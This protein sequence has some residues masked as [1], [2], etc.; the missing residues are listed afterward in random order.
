MV[1]ILN[2][3]Y[4][5]T[6]PA[7]V[8]TKTE[9]VTTIDIGGDDD[10]GVVLP[11]PDG[12]RDYN[13]RKSNTTSFNGFGFY[14]M[15]DTPYR[16]WQEVRLKIQAGE[17]RKHVRQ[18]PDRNLTFTVHVGDVQKVANTGCEEIAYEKVASLLREG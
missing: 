5:T 15:G 4:R 14:L 12:T 1:M 8:K 3:R 2:Y 10:D 6:P 11:K 18:N 9:I 17:M 16:D 13:L 7:R